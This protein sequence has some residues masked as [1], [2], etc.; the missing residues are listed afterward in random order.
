LIARA[1]RAERGSGIVSL[2]GAAARRASMGDF[3][4]IAA[5]GMVYDNQSETNPPRLVFVDERN[6]P[7]ELRQCVPL[8]TTAAQ[9]DTERA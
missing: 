1:I 5:F 2:N 3:V 9:R 4:I 7:I 8:Q 6:G